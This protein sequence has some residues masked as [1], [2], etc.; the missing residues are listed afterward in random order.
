MRAINYSYLPE[1]MQGAMQRYI[2]RGIQ[3]GS[4]LIAV[5]S[6]DLMGALKRGDDVNLGALSA[7]G[8]F[9]YCE[10]PRHCYGSL[11]HVNK[12]INQGGLAAYETEDAE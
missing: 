12:W 4:F 9:L 1:H 5:L 6:N 3:P 11:L 8:R 10:A 2:E 7:Y